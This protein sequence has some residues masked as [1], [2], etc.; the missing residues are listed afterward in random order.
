M[1]E[2]TWRE[3]YEGAVGQRVV[4]VHLEVDWDGVEDSLQVLLLFKT[5][6]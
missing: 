3:A 4:A 5:A 6:G 1:L 2:C